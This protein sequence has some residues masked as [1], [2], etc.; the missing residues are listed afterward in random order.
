MG[1]IIKLR[2]AVMLV[3]ETVKTTT[4]QG[5]TECPYIFI[6]GSGISA[7]EIVTAGGIIEHC[8]DR[9]KKLYGEESEEWKRVLED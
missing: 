9:V 2:E 7:P 3:W 6:V 8:K 1:E 5:G 4:E